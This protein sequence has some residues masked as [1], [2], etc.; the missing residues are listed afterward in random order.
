MR[1][2]PPGLGLELH[3]AWGG[4]RAERGVGGRTG[5]TWSS[6]SDTV[7]E[8]QWILRQATCGIQIWTSIKI[9][10]RCNPLRPNII[11]GVLVCHS[12]Y[13]NLDLKARLEEQLPNTTTTAT[14]VA[15]V[16]AP[17]NSCAGALIAAAAAAAAATAAVAVTVRGFIGGFSLRQIIQHMV[18]QYV[19]PGRRRWHKI[20]LTF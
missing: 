2:R 3:Q 12:T 18:R 1:P 8:N 9:C 5:E 15:S 13:K 19:V 14:H 4:G 6:D 17:F 11:V 20:S 10:T 7:S 16:S